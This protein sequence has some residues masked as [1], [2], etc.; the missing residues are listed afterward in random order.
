MPLST[1]ACLEAIGHHSAGF[2]DAARGALTARV[3]HCPEWS[4]ADLVWHLTEVHWFWAKIASERPVAPP[5]AADRPVRPSDPELVGVF[6]AGAARLVEV[7]GA[8]DPAAPCWTWAPQHQNVGFVV[9]HQVQEAA[10][11]HW[12]VAN[13]AGEAV[14]IAPAV[15]ADAVAEFLDVSLE[16]PFDG[17]LELRAVDTGDAWTVGALAPPGPPSLLVAPGPAAAAAPAGPVTDPATPGPLPVAAPP[18]VLAATAAEL[19]LW[20]YGRVALDTT[21][22]PAELLTAFRAQIDTD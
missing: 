4:V 18:P 9:R 19:L 12:D 6:T 15:A 1:A 7:L 14:A 22:V 17:A 16:G 11:H 3:E 13:A 2:A 5:G 8:A 21:A 20:L 10:V